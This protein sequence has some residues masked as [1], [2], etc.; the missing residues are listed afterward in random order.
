MITAAITAVAGLAAGG[1]IDVR[2]VAA[3]A[4]KADDAAAI[5]CGTSPTG[6]G[7]VDC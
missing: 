7:W 4:E 6:G 5:P 1:R 2:E 3:K